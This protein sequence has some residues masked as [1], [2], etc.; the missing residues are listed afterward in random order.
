MSHG[1]LRI[2]QI[3]DTHLFSDKD[4]ALLGVQPHKSLEGVLEQLKQ[5]TEKFDF[6]I[7]SGDL[8]Q[9]YS[10]PAY[11][12]VAE[13]LGVF[14]VPI[15]CVP[16]NHDDPKVMAQVYPR[17]LISND[18]H[19]VTKNW[20]FILLDS[21]KPGAVEGFLAHEQL[22]YL[23][24]C[25]HTYPEHHAIVLFHH[26]PIPVGSRWLDNLGLTNADELWNIIS[27]FPKLKNVLFGHVH[28]EFDKEV[29][30]IHCYST[31]STCFQFMRNQD[32]FGLENL[33]PGYRWINLYDD[34][35]IKTGVVR[36]PKYIGEFDIK[37]TGY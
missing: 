8:S 29:N 18:R 16:G 13:M 33:P 9:D 31:P 35:H 25:L 12:R 22:N 26:Q 4:K 19:I 30:G 21:H 28:Q 17:G 36:T 37:A 32:H 14:N 10:E 20:Q 5:D 1:P 3:S 2:I 15:Y 6:I 34:G 27:R 7:H 24:H 11:V 23:Q